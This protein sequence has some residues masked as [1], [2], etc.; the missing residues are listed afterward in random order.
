[1]LTSLPFA[2]HQ[3]PSS[4]TKSTD[5]KHTETRH[6]SRPDSKFKLMVRPNSINKTPTV[7]ANDPNPKN[8]SSIEI[9]SIAQRL[10]IDILGLIILERSQVKWMAPLALSQVCRLWRIAALSTPAAWSYFQIDSYNPPRPQFID[11]WLSRC[12]AI[13]CRLSFAPWASFAMVKAACDRAE[14][15]KGL[16][17]FNGTQV[18][19]GSFPNLEELRLGSYDHPPPL[20]WKKGSGVCFNIG[21]SWSKKNKQVS[22]LDSA[23]FPSLKV[24]HLHS[25]SPVLRRAIAQP[26]SFPPLRELHIST[27]DLGWEEIIQHC[28]DTLVTLG[29]QC[30]QATSIDMQ[31]TTLPHLRSLSLTVTD[32]LGIVDDHY[33]TWFKTPALQTYYEEL[34]VP[35]PSPIHY[36][37]SS[38][39]SATFVDAEIIEWSRLPHLSTVVLDM[40]EKQCLSV[41]EAL[42]RHAPDLHEIQ[43]IT[44]DMDTENCIQEILHTR[45]EATGKTIHLQAISKSKYEKPKDSYHPCF[46]YL[47]GTCGE[48]SGDVYKEKRLAFGG[49]LDDIPSLDIFDVNMDGI[50][51]DVF[52]TDGIEPYIPFSTTSGLEDV[53]VWSDD[54]YPWSEGAFW[55]D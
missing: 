14:A 7:P 26:G 17:L 46:T 31:A 51:H 44:G 55:W 3:G 34:C 28:A 43:W 6:R 54:P 40:I 1:M 21:D 52:W 45:A 29:I 24:L 39:T 13:T 4:G 12:G 8:S 18:L 15:L 53:D 47:P 19:T 27:S 16:S 22:L 25:P 2:T 38:V 20:E 32:S 37:T 50:F 49:Y 42:G 36:D 41:C 11:L 23:R 30:E 5:K 10:P 33:T 48:R 35:W 9:L